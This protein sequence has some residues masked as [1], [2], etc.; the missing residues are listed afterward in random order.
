MS[1][2]TQ[3]EPIVEVRVKLPKSILAHL[4]S[5]AE[6]A[7]KDRDGIVVELVQATKR[8]TLA[9]AVAPVHREFQEKGMCGAEVDEW[10]QQEVRAHREGR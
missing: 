4:D 10:A 3:A 1:S 7:G 8:S 5:L 6:A 2:E 9:K